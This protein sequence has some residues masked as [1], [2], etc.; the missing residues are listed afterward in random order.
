M[1]QEERGILRDLLTSLHELLCPKLNQ[2][3]SGQREEIAY[4]IPGEKRKPL[5]ELRL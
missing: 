2:S 1:R 5:E 3:L 4:H